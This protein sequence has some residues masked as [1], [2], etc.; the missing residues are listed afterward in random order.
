MTEMR[1]GECW[2]IRAPGHPEPLARSARVASSLVSRM[3]GLLGRR[4]LAEGEG[5]VIMTCQSIHTFFMQFSIDVIF[6]DADWRVLSVYPSIPPWR[7]T[8]PVWGAAAAIELPAGAVGT[9]LQVGDRL[10][11]TPA[12]GQNRLDTP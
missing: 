6:T 11:F 3:V 9:R 12:N 5:L 1:E 4:L 10:V 7:A 2:E 8:P